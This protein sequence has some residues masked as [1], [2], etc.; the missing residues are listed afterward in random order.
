MIALAAFLANWTRE[1]VKD[2]EDKDA[3]KGHKVTLPLIMKAEDVKKIVYLLLALTLIAGYL[4]TYAGEGTPYYTALVTMANVIFILAGKH[5]TH[6]RAAK[7][8]STLKKGMLIALLA[9][10]S[11]LV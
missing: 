6:G 9:Q 10:I 1:I 8:Q 4:P 5:V 3:D 2:M 7:A 11:L